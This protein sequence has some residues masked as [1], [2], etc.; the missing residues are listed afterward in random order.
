MNKKLLFFY[1][2]CVLS[3]IMFI[4][5]CCTENTVKVVSLTLAVTFML[6][7]VKVVVKAKLSN[8]MLYIAYLAFLLSNL[9]MLLGFYTISLIFTGISALSAVYV[10]INLVIVLNKYSRQDIDKHLDE[11]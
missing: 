9:I 7:I 8:K 11:L 5:S 3:V 2:S 6:A 4:V 10:I 1:I